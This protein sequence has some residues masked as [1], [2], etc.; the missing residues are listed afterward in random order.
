MPPR[1]KIKHRYTDFG[2]DRIEVAR[3]I[4]KY[5]DVF[6]LDALYKLMHEWLVEEGW[7]TRK[8]ED[9][10]EV[11]FLQKESPVSGK[12]IWFRWR[13]QKAPWPA[14]YK[15][16]RFVLDVDAHV[17]GLKPAELIFKGQKFSADKGEIEVTVV[18][19]LVVD[20]EKAWEKTTWLKSIKRLWVNRVV[21]R[22]R[23]MLRKSLYEEAYRLREA[24]TSYL[25]LE[26]YMTEREDL[27]FWLKR[28]LE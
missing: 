18:A 22:T 10:P 26:T 5:K 3:Y 12:E 20:Y 2:K 13:L 6:S 27:E 11:L 7:A 16:W 28:T 4:V 19:S 9:F 17:L 15:F 24:I 25:K 21:K 1:T 14:K 23:E 8:D